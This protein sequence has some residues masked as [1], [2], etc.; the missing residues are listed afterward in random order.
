M[1]SALQVADICACD[2]SH[3]L[4]TTWTEAT[5]NR[6]ER[7]AEIASQLRALR[8]SD[9]KQQKLELEDR[10]AALQA[11]PEQIAQLHRDYGTTD[12]TAVR[13]FIIRNL[14][15]PIRKLIVAGPNLSIARSLIE[16]DLRINVSA[17]QRVFPTSTERLTLDLMGRSP[18]DYALLVA[19]PLNVANYHSV[20]HRFIS[21]ARSG[22]AQDTLLV[23]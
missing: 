21:L 2:D 23:I 15:Q 18:S 6:Q 22:R 12:A 19:G 13:D 7:M 16:D 10:L 17:R 3:F 5:P 11:L 1:N 20:V 14:D 4:R 9:D 8:N